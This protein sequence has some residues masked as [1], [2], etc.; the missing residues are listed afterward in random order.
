LRDVPYEIAIGTENRRTWT[1]VTQ[2]VPS[3]E[4]KPDRTVFLHLADFFVFLDT[5]QDITALSIIS[6]YSDSDRNRDSQ[7]KYTN[8]VS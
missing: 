4:N 5:L 7:S 3:A 6:T 8:G 1:P 2:T